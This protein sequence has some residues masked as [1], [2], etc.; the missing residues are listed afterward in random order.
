M[1]LKMNNPFHNKY[2]LFVYEMIKDNNQG[3]LHTPLRSLYHLKAP[4]HSHGHPMD[5]ISIHVLLPK[6]DL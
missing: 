5:D 1:W 4:D 3:C 6:Q 2:E